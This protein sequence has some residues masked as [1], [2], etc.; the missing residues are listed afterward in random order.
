MAID[1]FHVNG[2]ALVYI[3]PYVAG[4]MQSRQLV[5]YTDNGV[6]MRVIENYSDII[7]DVM[8]PMTP[9]DIQNMGM[10]ANITVPLIASDRTVL[11][12]IQGRGD[13]TA[14]GQVSTPGL[15]MG[16]NSYQFMVSISSPADSP[17]NFL[18]CITRPGFETQ[19]ATKANPFT[20]E[21]FAWPWSLYTNTAG[22]DTTLYNRTAF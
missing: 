20:L 21:F 12:L 5:G 13:R 14:V 18:Y 22:K 8:G 1:G 6:R 7:T 17:W 2:T 10:V 4:V 11:A 15:V 16:A 3:A 19:L 9:H